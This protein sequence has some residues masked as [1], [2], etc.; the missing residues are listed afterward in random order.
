MSDYVGPSIFRHPTTASTN[1][2]VATTNPGK[3]LRVVGVNQK[4]A[5]RYLKIY[6]KA[7]VPVPATDVP[8]LTLLLP[9]AGTVDFNPKGHPFKNGLAIA[10]VAALADDDETVTE[11][12]QIIQIFYK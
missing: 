2:K 10:V 8:M 5:A 11:D 9:S 3:L 4:A 6:D 12:E 7:T 1:L